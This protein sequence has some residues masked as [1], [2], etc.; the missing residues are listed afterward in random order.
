MG[1][2]IGNGMPAPH[3]PSRTEYPPDFAL[4]NSPQD[5]VFFFSGIVAA[6]LDPYHVLPYYEEEDAEIF[7]TSENIERTTFE[8][9]FELRKRVS[10][11]DLEFWPPRH[12]HNLNLIEKF[13]KSPILPLLNPYPKLPEGPQGQFTDVDNMYVLLGKEEGGRRKEEGGRRKEEG[14]RRKGGR[15]K[16]ERFLGLK[17]F[18]DYSLQ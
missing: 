13:Y 12:S 9:F 11:K 7:G 8:R 15:R 2:M 1:S 6:L 3:P 10:P 17:R 5:P 18:L 14:G 4:Q 16:E